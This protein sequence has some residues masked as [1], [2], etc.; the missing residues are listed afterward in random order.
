VASGLRV[1]PDLTLPLDAVTQAIGILA[2]RGAGKTYTASVLVEE[3]VKAHQPVVVLDPTGA[4]WGLR[5]SADGER[6]G[7]PVII[8]G[9]EH[10]D[11]PL[12][13][14]AGTVIADLVV[15]HPGA[16]VV[17]LS[18]FESKAAEHRFAAA[19]LE[20]L[21]RAKATRREPLLL[22]V[23]EA[24]GF[25]PQRPGPEQARTLGALEAIV[26]R[27]RIRGL[28]VVLIT[29]R[30]AVLNKNVLTQIEVLVAMQTTGP[31]D[32]AAI[33]EW[34]SGNGSREE[35]DLVLGSLASLERGEAW[36]WSPSWLRQLK[37]VRI[38]ARETFDSS[39]TP[40][41]GARA[42]APRTFAKVD[43]EQL[44]ER[45]RATAE[46]AKA[47]DPAELRR[48]IAELERLASQAG[49]PTQTIEKIVEVPVLNGQVKDLRDVLEGLREFGKWMDAGADKIV[50]A[51]DSITAAIDRVATAPRPAQQSPVAMGARRPA[52]RTEA[53]SSASRPS[54]S[55]GGMVPASAQ[56][57]GSGAEGSVSLGKA[58]RLILAAL[59]QYPAG[60]TKTQVALLTGYSHSAG[61][62]NN[63]LGRLRSLALIEGGKDSITITATGLGELGGEWTPLPTGRALLDFW[64]AKSG[65]PERLILEALAAVYPD[66]LTKEE[67]GER[68][69]YSSEAGHFNN[70]LGKLRSLDLVRGGR[71]AIQASPDLVD[72][73]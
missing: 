59:A 11:V 34:V 71:S 9:G 68:T 54:P 45:I 4:W 53:P 31:Q 66:A 70:V 57:S 24:D 14:T 43:L 42:I 38:R 7:L 47:N 32:R 18:G 51:A 56:P 62:F 22:V 3:V 36:V 58:E 13:S 48:R 41:A 61:H 29:Q 69:G 52:G 64:L 73:Q 60:R 50:A 67:L 30:S 26:R 1:S 19:F 27:G 16:Y 37:R 55:T 5:S 46:Q 44:G 12:E 49:A 33:D 40:E 2:R 17:D 20:R 10:G 28:G 35:R 65:K 23:D 63:M 39:K 8:L 21:Y 6:P 15:D 25:A 72:V